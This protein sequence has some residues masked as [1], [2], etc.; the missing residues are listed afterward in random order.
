I[1]QALFYGGC[2]SVFLFLIAPI[3]AIVPLSFSSDSFLTYPLPGLSLRWYID[4]F[5]SSHWLPALANS[6][7]VASA[8]MALATVL[9]TLAAFGLMRMSA[10]L[11]PLIAS[12]LIA[13]M[14]VPGIITAIGMYFVYSPIGLT[15]SYAGL[16]LAH[17]V[18]ATPF[19]VMVVLATLQGLDTS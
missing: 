14:I 17:T 18:L 5:T 10:T 3:L 15:H 9:G 7:I 13:P 1:S 16:I 8:T 4:F 19:V 12:I 11:R 6:L 2:G